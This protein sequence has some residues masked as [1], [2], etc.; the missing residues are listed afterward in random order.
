MK[1]A[2]ALF[3]QLETQWRF[4]SVGLGG[5][6]RTGLDYGAIA[7]VAAPSDIVVTRALLDDIRTLERA[8]LT[9][10]SRKH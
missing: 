7:A 3:F 10:W 6:I 1:E 4:A 9:A 5:V 2:V 8:A